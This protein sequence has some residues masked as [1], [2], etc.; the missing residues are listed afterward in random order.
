MGVLNKEFKK[1]GLKGRNILEWHA[2]YTILL[3]RVEEKQ[4][5]YSKETEGSDRGFLY[6]VII[7]HFAIHLHLTSGEE[8]IMLQNQ[9]SAKYLEYLINALSAQFC[10]KKTKQS[11]FIAS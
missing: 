7:L 2:W 3:V 5:S 6:L 10:G 11:W 8:A 1:F 9:Q 4:A